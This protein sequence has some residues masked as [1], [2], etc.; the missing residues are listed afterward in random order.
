MPNRMSAPTWGII[1]FS[2]AVA[3]LL[4]AHGPAAAGECLAKPADRGHKAGHWYYRLDQTRHRR[5]WYFEASEAKAAPSAPPDEKHRPS[6]A[7]EQSWLSWFATGVQTFT[8][9]RRAPESSADLSTATP[10][11]STTLRKKDTGLRHRSHLASRA[12][13][14]DARAAARVTPS[15][16]DTLFRE[17]EEYL[18]RREVDQNIPAEGR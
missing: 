6:A 3:I 10:V 14:R 8:L 9:G 11:Q 4:G 18:R 13:F 2:I 17:F 16:H 1:A 7:P 5:C 12:E 15:G